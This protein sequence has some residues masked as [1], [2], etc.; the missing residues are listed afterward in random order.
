MSK[1]PRKRPAAIDTASH[2]I[3]NAGEQHVAGQ[4]EEAETLG[5]EQGVVV[6]AGDPETLAKKLAGIKRRAGYCGLCSD[7]LRDYTGHASRRPSCKQHPNSRVLTPDEWALMESELV[8]EQK[9][10][11]AAKQRRV[12][13]AKVRHAQAWA[14]PVDPPAETEYR[15]NFGKH[16]QGKGK[17]IQEVLAQDPGYFKALVSWKNNILDARCDLKTGLEK[18][19]ILDELLLGR[20]QLRRERAERIISREQETPVQAVVHREVKNLRALQLLEATSVL[21]EDA[22]LVDIVPRER[23]KK[24]IKRAYTP[25]ARVLLPHCSVCGSTDHKRPSCPHK[26]LQGGGIPDASLV[27]LT[28]HC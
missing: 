7:A 2:V 3:R 16:A 13:A 28:L 22:Q 18:A 6:V 19:G 12:A 27:P 14:P 8:E 15:M 17:T 26:D 21:Q 1:A 20:P 23:A 4:A 9:D 11:E 10:P 5:V 25:T 24:G